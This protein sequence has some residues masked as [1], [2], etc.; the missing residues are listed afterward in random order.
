MSILEMLTRTLEAAQ[1]GARWMAAPLGEGFG[2]EVAY[3]DDPIG[4]RRF[5]RIPMHGKRAELLVLSRSAR[6][7]VRVRILDLSAGGVRISSGELAAIEAA[8]RV[9]ITVPL[10][11]GGVVLGAPAVVVWVQHGLQGSTAGLEFRGIST[12]D[13][14]RIVMAIT[15]VAG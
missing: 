4:R 7:T 12:D 15:G 6:M 2:A 9:R 8:T 13:Q 14:R 11:D 1:A 5:Q 10:P 3:W